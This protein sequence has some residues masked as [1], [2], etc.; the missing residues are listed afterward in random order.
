VRQNVAPKSQMSQKDIAIAEMQKS[1]DKLVSDIA[2]NTAA[3]TELEDEYYDI[4]FDARRHQ[5]AGNNINL[6]QEKNHQYQL[7]IR[8]LHEE[9]KCLRESKD[10]S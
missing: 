2:K 6:L 9:I 3:I 7:Q 4:G 5:S 1:I 8:K 10:I